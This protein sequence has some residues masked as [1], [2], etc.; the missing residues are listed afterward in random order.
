[1]NSTVTTFEEERQAHR[2]RYEALRLA[3]QGEVARALPPASDRRL[4]HSLPPSDVS[5][6]EQLPG[7]WYWTTR[8]ARGDALRI[9]DSAGA[10]PVALLAWCVADP[11]ERIHLADTMKVQ[12]SA[13][14]CKGRIIYTD[15]GRVAL[16]IIEDSSGAHDALVGPTTAASM[17]S[18]LGEGVWRNSRD[19]F[20][21]ASAKLGLSRRDIPPCL[22]L[23]APVSVDVQGR[24]VWTENRRRPGD[25][26]DLRAEMDLWV[27]LSNA[28]HP[29]NPKLSACPP[30]VELLLHKPTASASE[31]CRHASPEA[32]RAFEFTERHL[33]Q[34]S[35]S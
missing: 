17:R 9:V 1:M 26:V 6:R 29:L 34:E 23:F 7:G 22:S 30:A 10:S 12:W 20:L 14:L 21:A 4:A 8:L 13:T 15:M 33:G 3:G 16:S 11:S 27:V 35:T 32:E 2:A 25:F 19:N 28:G 18:A 5:R 31:L 24:F